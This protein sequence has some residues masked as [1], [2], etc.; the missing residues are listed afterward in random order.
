MLSE[1]GA[2]VDDLVPDWVC[3]LPSHVTDAYSGKGSRPLA[4]P[5][6]RVLLDA[7]GYPG[8]SVLEH[9]LTFGF[10]AIGHMPLGTG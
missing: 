6:I 7:I 9:E 1:I 2:L 10:P 4:A 5:V 3:T 8:A